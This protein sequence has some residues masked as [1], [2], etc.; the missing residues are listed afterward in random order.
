MTDIAITG[1]AGRM[2]ARLLALAKADGSFN[3]VGAIE[4][5]EHPMQARDAGEV[6]GVGAVGTPITYDLKPTPNVLIDFTV[7][8]STRHWLKTCRDRGIAMLIGTT[9]LQPAD[10]ATID[11]AARDIPILQSPNMSL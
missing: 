8:A 11:Q 3:I 6:A 9:G 2:G 10:H 1:A 7:P 5:P 4:R